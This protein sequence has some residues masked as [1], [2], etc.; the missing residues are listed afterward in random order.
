MEGRVGGCLGGPALSRFSAT[1]NNPAPP[2][3][4]VVDSAKSASGS[5]V[6]SFNQQLYVPG[7][8][9]S[10]NF[11]CAPQVRCFMRPHACSSLLLSRSNTWHD[12][13]YAYSCYTSS[14]LA[15]FP[16]ISVSASCCPFSCSHHRHQV[17]LLQRVVA[18]LQCTS[19]LDLSCAPIDRATFCQ[20][21]PIPAK[22]LG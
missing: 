20:Q 11:G 21:G 22:R 18:Y 9:G 10:Q 14:P 16:G 15:Y 12:V 8:G 6:L 13:V 17:S 1:T 19:L 3:F 7:G 5:F 4:P 2:A